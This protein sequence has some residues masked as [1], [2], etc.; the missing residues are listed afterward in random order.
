LNTQTGG[1][2]DLQPE[3]SDTFTIGAIIQPRQ[4]D[5][6][7]VSVDYFNISVNDFIGTI[8]SATI[9]NGCL[10]TANPDLCALVSRSPLDGS[11]TQ[12][13]SFINIQTQNVASRDTSGLDFQVDYGFDPLGYGNINLNYVSTV[14]FDLTQVVSPGAAGFDCTGFFDDECNIGPVYDYRHN[15]TLSYDAPYNIRVSALWRY[16]SG[17]ER[18][19][20]LDIPTGNL[21]TFVEDNGADA[22]IR[23]DSLGSESFV[24]LAAFYDV[25]EHLEL[26][27]GVNNVFD[28]TPGIV[29]FNT[30]GADGNVFSNVL[31]STGRFIFVGAKLNF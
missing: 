2:V 13:G 12:D 22:N 31:T 15:L 11:L 10:N 20:T 18:V 1:N 26:R 9:L 14:L 27:F 4:I 28:N 29:D 23:G 3:E 5:G 7:T 17:V 24:D 30:S 6:L 16:F 21:T 19:G 8:P 25:N